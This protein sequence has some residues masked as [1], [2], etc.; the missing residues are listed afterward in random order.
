MLSI[1]GIYFGF[2]GS[3]VPFPDAFDRLLSLLFKCC[4]VFAVRT[5]AALA[6]N[7]RRETFAIPESVE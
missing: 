2:E 7:K 5:V 6:V 4:G 3:G 1:F